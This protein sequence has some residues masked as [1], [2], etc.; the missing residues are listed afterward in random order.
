MPQ[1]PHTLGEL[2]HA[3]MR[4][5]WERGEASVSEVHEAFQ[6][7]RGLAP[8]TLATMLAKMERKG[9]VKH[10]TEGRRFVYRAIV[11]ERVVRLSMVGELMERLFDGDPAALVSHLI[12]EHSVDPDELEALRRLLAKHEERNENPSDS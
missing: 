6:K 9:V 1:R 11:S 4:L 10:R 5:L 7:E 2:Q 12:A 3:I 8:T